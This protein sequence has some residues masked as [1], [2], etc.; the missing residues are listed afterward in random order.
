M[1]SAEE[2]ERLT[3]VGAGTPGGEMLRRYWQVVCPVIE[4][5]SDQRTRRVTLLG[6]KLV[7]YRDQRG[8]FVDQV[9]ATLA[10][11]CGPGTYQNLAGQTSCIDAPA[12]SF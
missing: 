8:T 7:V 10:T 12:G 11:P 2:N 3:Q 1:I 9:G 5:A 4:L 6:E